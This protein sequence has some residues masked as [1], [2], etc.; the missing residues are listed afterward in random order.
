MNGGLT[1]QSYQAVKKDNIN[2]VVEDGRVRYC[3][4]CVHTVK[5]SL[6]SVANKSLQGWRTGMR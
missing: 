1:A 2:A 6:V 3:M 5:S 4:R